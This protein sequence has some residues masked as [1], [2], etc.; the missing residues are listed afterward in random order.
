MNSRLVAIC[1]QNEG[2]IVEP[3]RLTNTRGGTL[4]HQRVSIRPAEVE[5]PDLLLHTTR[6]D[7]VTILREQR[8]AHNVLV[9]KGVQFIPCDG[10]PN[11][12]R[13]VGRARDAVGG[14]KVEVSTPYRALV[15]FEGPDP[16]AALSVTDHRFPVFAGTHE[17]VAIFGDRA[18]R[19]FNDR[20]GV[21]MADQGDLLRTPRHSVCRYFASP[22][23]L[24]CI[25]SWRTV[26]AGCSCV[27]HTTGL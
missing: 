11:A 27:R 13:E 19:Y 16:V 7:A 12:S 17:K 21:T 25:S 14:W 3:H 22:D 24:S 9:L 2:V 26:C 20:A 15:A 8:G 4:H 23:N 5:N 18:V 1:A 6:E 10:V